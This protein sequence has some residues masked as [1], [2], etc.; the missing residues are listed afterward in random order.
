MVSVTF[1]AGAVTSTGC[2]LMCPSAVTAVSVYLPAARPVISKVPSAACSVRFMLPVPRTSTAASVTGAPSLYATLPRRVTPFSTSMMSG[3]DFAVIGCTAM[4]RGAMSESPAGGLTL[5]EYCPSVSR[6]VTVPLES[7]MRQS[8]FHGSSQLTKA[9]EESS[10]ALFALT[11]TPGTAWCLE[12]TT[13]TCSGKPGGMLM[14]MLST[15]S[16]LFSR[17]RGDV[18]VA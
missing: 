4:R 10:S 15:T 7:V 11:R 3:E 1:A 17:R 12:S 16:P 18:P 8:S 13:R 6:R 9:R 14:T 2:V 5:N